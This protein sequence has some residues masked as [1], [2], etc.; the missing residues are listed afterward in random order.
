MD[1]ESPN[2][3]YLPPGFEDAEFHLDTGIDPGLLPVADAYRLKRVWNWRRT[4]EAIGMQE[5]RKRGEKPRREIP[6]GR[7]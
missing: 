7:G 6:R 4:M 1:P 3:W 5:I 2:T